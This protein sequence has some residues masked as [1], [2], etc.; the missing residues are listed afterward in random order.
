MER[1]RGIRGFMT[2]WIAFFLVTGLAVLRSEKLELH[3][4]MHAFHSDIADHFFSTVTHLGDGL[5]PTGL[6]LLL[7]FIRDLRSFLM[8]GLSCGLSA[9]VVQVLKRL[10]FAASDRPFMF[11]DHLG[12]MHWVPG[13]ELHHHFSFPSG[14][15]TAAFSMCFALAVLMPGLLRGVLF[16]FLAALMAYSR[17]YLS[18][19]FTEDILAGSMIGTVTACLVYYWLYLSRTSKKPW[20]DRSVLRRQN[21]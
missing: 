6:S 17:V 16:A 3:R 4:E 10:P 15:A 9:I 20:L 8:M 1:E 13:L 14:H 11:K 7:L 18:Q 19:H 21:Q 2:V 5:V 12:D